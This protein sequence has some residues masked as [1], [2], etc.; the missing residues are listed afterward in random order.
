[1]VLIVWGNSSKI[2]NIL[3]LQKRSV[4]A[5]SNAHDNEHC[6]PLFIKLNIHRSV[7]TAPFDCHQICRQ[8]SVTEMLWPSVTTPGNGIITIALVDTLS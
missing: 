5:I 8:K 6:Q 2:N 3:R 1:M 7:N 4:R